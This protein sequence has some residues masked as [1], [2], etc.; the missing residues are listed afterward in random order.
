MAH[1]RVE[2][3]LL[4]LHPVP[5]IGKSCF[6]QMV[7]VED[8][9]ESQHHYDQ[10][11]GKDIDDALCRQLVQVSAGLLVHALQAL[12]LAHHFFTFQQQ[13]VCIIPGHDGRG[14]H[15]LLLERLPFEDVERYL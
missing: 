14:E 8:D 15:R 6:L 3:Q 1:L 11:H 12:C 5:F 9:D 7:E 10:Y 13:Y 4:A 2:V